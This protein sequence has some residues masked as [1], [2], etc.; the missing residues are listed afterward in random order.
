MPIASGKSFP[1]RALSTIE[2]VGPL[3]I[4]RM[5]F[6]MLL[7]VSIILL[8]ESLRYPLKMPG[9]HGLEGMALLLLGRLTCTTRWA[10]TIVALS[11]AAMS[12]ATNAQHD[13]SSALLNIAPGVIIDLAVMVFKDW[14]A[15]L[16]VMPFVAAFAHAT[17]P[18]I[19][20][21]IAEGFGITFGSLRAGVLYPI[22]THLV[23]G[24]AGGL[25]AV[26]LWRVTMSK[27]K[28]SGGQR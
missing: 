18:L 26:I 22:S 14:R 4:G 3:T 12:L 17:K 8:H 13:V 1:A 27:W 24:F 16:F 7:G 21:G 11:A 28:Q 20:F 25:T 9:H 15:Q 6:L 23:Y 19:R 10:A 5:L 2:P